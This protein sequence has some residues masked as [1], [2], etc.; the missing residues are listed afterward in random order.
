MSKL[1]KQEL[2]QQ[3]LELENSIPEDVGKVDEIPDEVSESEHDAAPITKPKK[4]VLTEKQ[5]EALKKGQMKR[6]ENAKARKAAALQKAE[7]ER[8]AIEDKLVK[9]AIS[10]KKKQ[11]KKQAILD[12][13]SDDD[14][15]IEKIK[16][17][18]QRIPEKEFQKPEIR[19]F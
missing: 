4:K 3:L 5:K 6:D 19:F 16:K 9:K 1:S 14:T 2:L 10:I 11:I 15:P 17:I 8:K 18:A 12:E 13:L 7:E